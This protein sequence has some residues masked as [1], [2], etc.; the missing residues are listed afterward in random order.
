MHIG[1]RIVEPERDFLACRFQ[2][3]A[4]ECVLYFLSTRKGDSIDSRQDRLHFSI[5]DNKNSAAH[6]LCECFGEILSKEEGF[7][8]AR[9]PRDFVKSN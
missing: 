7:P 5:G 2:I 4:I 3:I 6:L 1:R 8:T 9:T